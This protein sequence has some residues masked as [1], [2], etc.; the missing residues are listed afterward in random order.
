MHVKFDCTDKK[1]IAI[2]GVEKKNI[3][4]F[5]LHG[6]YSKKKLAEYRNQDSKEEDS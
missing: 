2:Q 6:F 3:V 5:H 4:P 1:P